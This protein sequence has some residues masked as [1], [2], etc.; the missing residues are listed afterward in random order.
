MTS[1]LSTAPFLLFDVA[2]GY[3]T[4]YKRQAQYGLFGDIVGFQLINSG[5]FKFDAQPSLD[6]IEILRSRPDLIC[7]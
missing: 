4:R 7:D 3:F 1:S 2:T 6:E 5:T